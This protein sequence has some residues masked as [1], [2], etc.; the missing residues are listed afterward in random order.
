MPCAMQYPID[1]SSFLNTN[2]GNEHVCAEHLFIYI[3]YHNPSQLQYL[4][5]VLDSKIS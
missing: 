4:L 1:G 3:L 5:H 2:D